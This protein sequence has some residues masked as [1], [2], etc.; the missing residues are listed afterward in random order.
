[1]RRQFFNLIESWKVKKRN[2][3]V[4][5]F[6]VVV[7]ISNFRSIKIVILAKTGESF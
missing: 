2:I 4:V 1:M 3:H 5:T 7:L 6:D